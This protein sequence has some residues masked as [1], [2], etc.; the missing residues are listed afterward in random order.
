MLWVWVNAWS[1]LNDVA[2]KY[3]RT[4]SMVQVQFGIAPPIGM[5]RPA[6]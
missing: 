1:G 5:D 6:W 2:V 3:I 4:G